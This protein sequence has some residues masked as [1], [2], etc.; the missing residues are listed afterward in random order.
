M[1]VTWSARAAALP[2][3]GRPPVDLAERPVR[4]SKEKGHEHP[5]TPLDHD[6]SPYLQ[7]PLRTLKMARE[8]RKRRQREAADT[9]AKRNQ[10]E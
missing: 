4:A 3:A 10:A 1:N 6:V 9:E 5:A 2:P 8:D 7:R